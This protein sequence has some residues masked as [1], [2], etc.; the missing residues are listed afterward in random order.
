MQP[1]FSNITHEDSSDA[2][3]VAL[4]QKFKAGDTAAYAL[5]YQRYFRVLFKYSCKITQDRNLILDTIQELFITV[6]KNKKNLSTPTSVR[7]YL[8]KSLRR[9]LYRQ[10]NSPHT[11]LSSQ[12]INESWGEV[13]LPHEQQLIQEQTRHEQTFVLSRALERLTRRQRE[14]IFLRFY[15][16]L[17]YTEISA[18]MAIGIEAVYNLLS[19]AVHHLQQHIKKIDFYTVLLLLLPTFL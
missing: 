3:D 15:Q 19:K 5:L 13:T 12:E 7:H 4:W 17:S 2:L 11:R 1:D 9:K 6:W 8:F 14:V 10:L 16:N 18:V